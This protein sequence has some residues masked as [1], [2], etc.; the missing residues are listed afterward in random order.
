MA[1]GL[2]VAVIGAG[3][4]GRAHAA[5]YRT[6]SALYSPVLPP[7]RLVSIA[8]VNAEL[9]SLAARRF[10][11][12]RNDTSW[13][14][15]AA[16]D[17]IDVVSVVIANSL[18]REVVEGLLAAGKHVLC[19]KPLSDTLD[20]ARAMADAARNAS[21][22]AK[23]GYTFR[24]TPGIAYIRE[25][26]QS[27]DLGK[28]LHFS[29]RY[30]TDYGCDPQGPMSWR[31]QGPAGSGALADVGSHVA[32]VSEF[33]CGDMTSVSGGQLSTVIDQRPLP[34]AAVRGHDH[35]EVS[36][37][38]EP[39]TNDDY[40]AFSATFADG[41]GAIEV[42]RVA[43]GHANS[44]IFDVFCANGAASFDQRRPA[45]IQLFLREGKS[46]QAGYRRVILGPEHPYLS[47]G[48]AMDAPSVGFGQNDAFAYQARAFL[49]EVAG[50]DE[51]SSLPRCASFND[52]VHNM[53]L[54][55]A[56][57]ESAAHNGNSVSINEGS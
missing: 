33:L 7:I 4:A 47:G 28:V 8:D 30:W 2:G 1:D 32:Y 21:S 34:L 12:E 31:F 18:H 19:E 39:V 36:D 55:A 56:V 22:I 26:I 51:A 41:V 24:R 57:A 9:G 11:Y 3:M 13:Q 16:A 10:G 49:E 17:D 6:A 38:F 52:G 40:A 43:A 23:I 45:E 29:G 25:L 37:V 46:S 35:A 44:L 27:G 42:S 14:A 53:E 5:A 20:E 15:I 54:L 50:I 48:L